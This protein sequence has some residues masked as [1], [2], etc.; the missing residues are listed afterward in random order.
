MGKKLIGIA[1]LL[2]LA[3]GGYYVWL[4]MQK[5]E[6]TDDAQVDGSII[7]VSSRIPGQV[8]E[9]M[10]A[11]QQ[12][13]NKGDV[14][15]KLDARDF[16]VAV[17]KAQADLE[18]ALANLETFKTDVPLMT[19]TTGSTLNGAKSARL[20]ASAAISWAEKQMAAAQARVAVAQA[21]VKVAEANQTKADQD[22]QR[23]RALVAKDEISKQQ[24]DQAVASA[25]AAKAT[26]DAQKAS[27]VEAQHGIAAAEVAIDQAKARLAQT[28]AQVAAAMTGPQQV[29]VTE[30]RVKAGLARVAQRRADLEQAKLNVEYTTIVA[31]ATGIIGRKTVD[32]G[33][34]VGPGQ[35]ILAIVP[36]D[37]LYVTANF[38]ETQLRNIKPGQ[39]VKLEV[40]ANGR[41]Y[42]GKVAR[43]AGASGA[44]FSL[45]PPENAAGNYVKVVQ[46]IPV[47]IEFDPGQNQDHA[48]R[49]GM[50]VTPSVKVQ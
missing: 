48:L 35:Q 15:A 25:A 38:K 34:N 17:N 33:Q 45:L 36:L 24:F 8:T 7:S 9:V 46:R 32:V 40:D 12:M 27:V 47:R 3:G 26:V 31:P 39:T 29:A 4:E 20:D 21:N 37:D 6:S 43:I 5:T 18:D 19:A 1:V 13:V 44:K 30:T 41:E 2:V 16:Q 22:V 50:S 23:Y 42:N 10:V 28:D 11:D 49:P 14:L